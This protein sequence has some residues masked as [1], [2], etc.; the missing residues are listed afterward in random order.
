MNRRFPNTRTRGLR[1]VL[2]GSVLVATVCVM[3]ED[4]AA[5]NFS[6]LGDLPGGVFNSRAID[7]SADGS[8]V[9]GAGTS[10][11]GQEAFRWTVDGGMVGLG[12]LPGGSFSSLASDVSA[13]GAVVVGES[14]ST[15]GLEAFRWTSG[16]GMVG[17][18]DLPGGSFD[19]TA[20]GVSADGSIVVGRS[21]SASGTEAFRWT[22]GGGMVGLGDLPGGPFSSIAYNVSTDGS[23]IVGEGRSASGSEAFRWTSGGGM[24][25]LGDLPGGSFSS[26]AHGVSA[27]GLVVVGSSQSASGPEAF[28]WTSGSG[29]VGLGDLPGGADSSVAIDVSADGSVVVG[30]S[31]SAIGTTAFIWDATNGMRNLN[32]L[33][34]AILG[35]ALDGWTLN[36]VHGVSADGKT[37]VG[38]GPSPNGLQ[39]WLAYLS[40]EVSWLPGGSGVWDS[41]TSWTGTFVPGQLDHVKIDPEQTLAV[42]G[43]AANQTIKSL[44]LGGGAGLATLRLNGTSSGDLTSLQT[45]TVLSNGIL[46]LSN[47]RTFTAPFISNGGIIRGD[48]VLAAGLTVTGTGEVRV[49]AGERIHVVNSTQAFNLGKIELIGTTGAP[50]EIEFEGNI[51]N[52]ANPGVIVARNAILRF[53]GGLMNAGV[54]TISFGTTDVFGDVTNFSGGTIAVAGNSGVTFYDDVTNNATLN[55]HAGS[56][57]VF[58][59]A[60]SGSGNVGGGEVQALGD[61]VPGASPGLMAF[62]GN[63]TLGPLTSLEVELGGLSP[64]GQFDQLDVAGAAMLAGALDLE[65]INGFEPALDDAFEII[66]AAGGVSGMF[67]TLADE[68]PALSPGLEWAINYGANGVVLQVVAAGLAG[69]YNGNG[70]VD[71]ADYT[72]WRDHLGQTFTLPNED[73]DTTPGQVTIE[74]YDFWKANFGNMA[75]GGGAGSGSAGASHSLAAVPEPAA[76]LLAAM[77]LAST[78]GTLTRRQ[79]SSR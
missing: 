66:T 79:R 32:D 31:S 47:G 25:G 30:L 13:D 60:L 36:Q 17:L 11:S 38:Y 78:L 23:V 7:I 14:N 39:A 12:E 20:T 46:Q 24:V 76:L 18:G 19:S 55:V 49:G 68:L 40:D 1:S 29:M 26:I 75:A 37:I 53:H 28:R 52:S 6:G 4:G 9:V 50:A 57:A 48:G 54:M 63:L 61:L 8:V 58:F 15:S 3:A 71:A 33:L 77:T 43:P 41:T 64:G 62:G 5:L 74:D 56:T 51:I 70:V 44:S 2:W 67:D 35:A 10:A 34:P 45:A 42:T 16:G 21:H 22:S 72:A 69:D 73:P 27:D 65:L 59:G